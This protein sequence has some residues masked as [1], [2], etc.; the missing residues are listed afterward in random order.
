MQFPILFLMIIINVWV[1]KEVSSII[2][3]DEVGILHMHFLILVYIVGTVY[4]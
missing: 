4:R 2:L 1:T 3:L